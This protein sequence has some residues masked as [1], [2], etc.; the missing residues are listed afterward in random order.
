[1]ITWKGGIINGNDANQGV[2]TGSNY[3]TCKGMVFKNVTNLLVEKVTLKNIRGHGINHWNCN[4]ATFRDIQVAQ[5]LSTLNVNGGSRRDGVTGMSS[6][7][8]IENISGFSDDDLVAVL[9][10]VDWAGTN[11]VAADIQNI[12]VRNIRPQKHSSG[13]NPWRAVAIYTS[14]GFTST[15]LTVDGLYGDCNDSIILIGNYGK[16][17]RGNVKNLTVTNVYGEANYVYTYDYGQIRIEDVYINNV[18]FKNIVSNQTT[19]TTAKRMLITKNKGD[20]DRVVLDNV[21]YNVFIDTSDYNAI[22]REYDTGNVLSFYASQ[23][24]LNFYGTTYTNGFL[25]FKNNTVAMTTKLYLGSGIF[26]SPPKHTNNGTS[27]NDT[28]AQIYATGSNKFSLTDSKVLALKTHLSGSNGDVVKSPIDGDLKFVNNQFLTITTPTSG[29]KNATG[30]TTWDS[31]L[32]ILIFDG[33][34]QSGFP[35]IQD[36]QDGSVLSS[37]PDGY[38]ITIKRIDNNSGCNP[39][40][41]LTNDQLIDGVLQ[42]NL[43]AYATIVLEYYGGTWY[44]VG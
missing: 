23:V 33:T 16:P 40:I 21:V 9:S 17:T 26:I 6:N 24:S 7:L 34:G 22:F 39:Y 42:T 20:I 1:N 30:F 32:K 36:L 5:G 41:R 11:T 25:Y 44:R 14:G 3:D 31:S 43:N 29:K 4:Y 35:R 10:G 38:R 27:T 37:Y 2:E 13:R 19:A 18:T 8:L 12:V 15:N 28:K